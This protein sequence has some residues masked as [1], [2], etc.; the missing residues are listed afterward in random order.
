MEADKD[1]YPYW[2]YKTANDDR[3]RD[4]HAA[5]EGLIFRIGDPEGDNCMPENG[6]NCR[7]SADPVDDQYLDENK[8]SAVSN[9]E[10]GKLLNDN[11]D[12]QFR[13][14]PGIQGPLPN[15]GS[16]FN[17]FNTANNGNYS[18][19]NLPVA[20]SQESELEGLASGMQYFMDTVNEWRNKYKSNKTGD[21]IFQNHDLQTNVRL[22]DNVLHKIQKHLKGFENIPTAI[23]KPNEVWS[24]WENPKHQRVTLRS[25]IL[26]GKTNYIVTTR[27][28]IITDAFA[29]N[30]R[31]C[32]SYR[33]GVIL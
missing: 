1:L 13:N 33:K 8:K 2:V 7:C 28:G 3:V 32:N 16:Y 27:D 31:V 11:I 19:F 6:W 24:L 15:E 30:N 4:E 9:D 5:L 29:A 12:E 26:F 18:L 22:T 25:Y 14:N 23:E 20:S 21:I 10:A 17:E